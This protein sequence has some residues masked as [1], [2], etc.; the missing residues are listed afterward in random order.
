[1]ASVLTICSVCVYQYVSVVLPLNKSLTNFRCLVMVLCAWTISIF[2][3]IGPVLYWGRY[4]FTSNIFNCEYYHTTKEAE[5]SYN[6]TL[7]LCGYLFPCAFMLFSYLNVL[8]ALQKHQSRMAVYTSSISP[9]PAAGSPVTLETKLCM[10]MSVVFLTFVV[11]RTPFFVFLVLATY[12][13]GNPPDFLGQLSFWAIYLH[14]ACDPF[15]YAF[16]HTEFQETL[17]D[18]LRTFR[19]AI[20][21]SCCFC[22]SKDSVEEEHV[23]KEKKW[24]VEL[25]R[26]LLFKR[27]QMLYIL[28][29]KNIITI[30]TETNIGTCVEERWGRGLLLLLASTGR[31]TPKGIPFSKREWARSLF[32]AFSGFRYMKG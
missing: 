1:M 11:C 14:S 13:L 26:P 30:H 25:A 19:L 27:F 31:L 6:I 8:R 32:L 3:A 20:T 16:K 17:R 10:T 4:E 15:I 18:I 7:M 9:A 29:S 12:D 23:V 2:L 28:L 24:N 21:A 22:S 5:I